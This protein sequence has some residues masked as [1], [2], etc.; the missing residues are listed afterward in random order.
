MVVVVPTAVSSTRVVDVRRADLEQ[1]MSDPKVARIV[2]TLHD[3]RMIG[4]K[5]YAIRPGSPL[6]AIGLENGD[7]LLAVND[8]SITTAD[9]ILELY[10]IH[11]A[12]DHFDLDIERRG[13]RVRILV[14]VHGH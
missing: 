1:A 7:T 5:L 6:T 9:S 4:V 8:V 10:R 11:A 13:E 12:P 14:L 2:P 3:G